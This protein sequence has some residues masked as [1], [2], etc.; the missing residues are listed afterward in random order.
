MQFVRF[1]SR[2]QAETLA[3]H[4]KAAIISVHDQDE[5]PAALAQGWAER[6]TLR[7]HDVDEQK[8]GLETFNHDMARQ[9]LEFIDRNAGC[10]HLIVHC[11]LGQSR[12]GAIALFASE[13][14]GV[15]CIKDT[16]PINGLSYKLYN[17]LVYRKL[18]DVAWG[19]PG[20]G[21]LSQTRVC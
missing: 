6:L 9:C 11:Q 16:L 13:F 12:S 8:P 1:I 7:F 3:A 15:P 5:A 18:A 10:E 17:R 14:L 21:F 2:H 20:A 4:P 19:E